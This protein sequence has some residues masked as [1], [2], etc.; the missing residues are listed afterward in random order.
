M[1]SKLSGGR[2]PEEGGGGGG[3]SQYVFHERKE[4]GISTTHVRI[5]LI[6][7]SVR[8]DID[9]L[10]FIKPSIQFSSEFAFSSC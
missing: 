10:S 9:V 7:G 4:G 1:D 3:K 6:A 8:V 2:S 5:F